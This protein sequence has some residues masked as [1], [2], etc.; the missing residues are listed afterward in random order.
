MTQ[1][2][3]QITDDLIAQGIEWKEQPFPEGTPHDAKGYIGIVTTSRFVLASFSIEDQGFEAGSRGYDG[4]YTKEA[5][6]M[7]LTREQAE[8][9]CKDAE[10]KLK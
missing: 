1:D 3:D 10:S 2:M 8:R 4:T 9:L 6:V 7:R 5:L